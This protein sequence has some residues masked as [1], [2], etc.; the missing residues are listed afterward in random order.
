[1]RRLPIALLVLLAL[2]TE[3]RAQ[4]EVADPPAVADT[5]EAEE[6][7]SEAPEAAAD[8]GAAD[9]GE[10]DDGE[11]SDGEPSDGEPTDG[12]P[13]DG[14]PT[15]GEASDGE[16]SG[17]SDSGSEGS[18]GAAADASSEPPVPE[19]PAESSA[20]LGQTRI[21]A[22]EAP[23]IAVAIVGD[24]DDQLRALAR[25]ID[26][27]L[28]PTL[29]RP[30]DPGLRAALRGEAGQPDDGLREVRRDRRRLSGN[31]AHDAPLLSELGRR[32][33]ALVV[34]AV[35]AGEDGP[36][37]VIL[38]VR[39]AAFYEGALALGE[40]SAEGRVLA[41]IGRRA[42]AAAHVQAIAP[43]AVAA[44]ATPEPTDAPEEGDEEDGF[45]EQFWPYLIAGVLLAGMIA[46]IAATSAADQPSQPV[47]RF[48]PGGG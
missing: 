26:D 2:S 44:A 15:D 39:H 3:A 6:P 41:F 29:R 14:E 28:E 46:A 18:A 1:M 9:D 42:R 11:P 12:E 17:A 4:G 16:P 31:E 27:A 22:T 13:T 47:L 32:A 43:D 23:K 5:G 10:S 25:R 21:A 8:D 36:E 33:G 24:P 37:L 7:T 34:A 45:F 38:D 19:V 35:R 20:P 40:M 30:F 48:V